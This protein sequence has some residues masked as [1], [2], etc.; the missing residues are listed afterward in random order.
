MEN[1]EFQN[2]TY[3]VREIKLPEFGIVKISTTNLDEVLMKKG[4]AYISKQAQNIDEKIFFF[5]GEDEI[6]LDEKVLMKLILQSI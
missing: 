4:S 2:K 1:V 5:V 6:E 3:K